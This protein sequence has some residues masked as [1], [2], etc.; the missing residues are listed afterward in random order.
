MELGKADGRIIIDTEI[1]TSGIELG[2]EKLQGIMLRV[3]K[4]IS[5]IGKTMKNHVKET[6]DVFTDQSRLYE[7]QERTLGKEAVKSKGISSETPDTDE[8]RKLIEEIKELQSQ[9]DLAKR[10]QALF[11]EA[12]GSAE[13]PMYIATA[14]D[15]ERINQKLDEAYAKLQRLEGSQGMPGA[16]TGG[17]EPSSNSGK[18]S[19]LAESLKMSFSSLTNSVVSYIKQL[20]LLTQMKNIAIGAFKRFGKAVINAA[21]KISGL[22]KQTKKSNTSFA[23]S[24]KTILKYTIGIRSMYVLFNRIRSGIKEG[25]QNLAQYSDDT[26]KDISMLVSSLTRLKNSFATAFSPILSVVAPILSK[27]INMISQAATYV[28]MFFA[29]LT[30]KGTFTKAVAVQ[31]DYAAGLE[32]TGSAAKDAAKELKGYL[33]PIDEINKMEKQDTSDTSS[34]GAGAGGVSPSQMFET[35]NIESPIK[36]IA[37]K[38]RELIQ[39]EDWAGLGAYIADGVN[40]GFQKLYSVLNWDTYGPQITYF[41]NALTATL[42]SLM[43]NIDW[44]LI[45][46]TFG[47]GIN[48]IVSTLNLLIEN[49]DFGFLGFALASGLMSMI[50][51]INWTNLGNF[52]GN[53]FMIGWRTFEGFIKNLDFEK[54]GLSLSELINGAVEKIDLTVIGS[55]LSTLAVGL[56]NMLSVAI[57]NTDWAEIGNKI[58]Q[59]LASVDWTGIA[60]SLFELIGSALGGLAEFIGGLIG[61]AVEEAKSYFQDKIEEAGGDV[62]TGILFGIADGLAAVGTWIKEHVFAPILEGFQKAFGIHSPSTVMAEQGNFLMRGLFNGMTSLLDKVLSIF[63]DLENNIRNAFDNIQNNIMVP[64]DKFLQGVFVIDWSEQFGILGDVMN[65]FMAAVEGIWNG[66][67]A[68]FDGFMTFLT[69][70]FAGNWEKAL[71]GLA[72]VFKGMFESLVGFARAPVNVIIGILNGLISGSTSAINAVIDL[73]NGLSFDVPDWV[74][75]LGGK[76]FGFDIQKFE[77][78]RIPYLATGAVIPPNAPFMAM[79]GDQRNGNNLEMPESLLRRIVREETGGSRGTGATYRFIGQINRRVL[80]EEVMTEARLTQERSGRNPFE[81]A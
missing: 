64:F 51:E 72:Q 53:K 80:F 15:I 66:I 60:D 33:S 10:K 2:S 20:H 70:V 23:S 8:Y 81:L 47:A 44:N 52:I 58:S 37:N 31:Q 40:A 21:T 75:D 17:A 61:D 57:Q 29:A 28:G 76:H 41:V 35:V 62:A 27:F 5:L 43:Y 6:G 78:P 1:D 45:G 74:P 46:A 19:Q 26:N 39:S 18:M 68:V 30:G 14:Q 59:G 9:L 7:Q 67:K 56:M 11:I 63:M 34:G 42:N 3:G 50:D 73:L 69:G 54:I 38:I 32:K 77:P 16:G 71:D 55:S 48:T 24:L 13:N 12:G 49:F 36:D 65:G 25:F 79:L 4:K 22:D